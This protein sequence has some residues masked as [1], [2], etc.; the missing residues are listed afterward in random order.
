MWRGDFAGVIK[1]Y[2]ENLLWHRRMPSRRVSFQVGGFGVLLLALK[3]GDTCARTGGRRR[4]AMGR[5][6]LT[7]SKETGLSPRMQGRNFGQW[8]E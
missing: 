4:V 3:C 5:P 8:P 1:V 7:A 6:H 2:A